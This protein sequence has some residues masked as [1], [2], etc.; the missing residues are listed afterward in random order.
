MRNVTLAMLGV[1]VLVGWSGS[2]AAQTLT[3]SR[4][5]GPQADAQK[6]LLDQYA[7]EHG[8]EIRFDAIDYGQ[9][10][11]KQT[12]NMS[13]KTG[14]YDLIYV[15]EAWFGEYSEAGYL[16]PLTKYVENPELTGENWDM[17]DFS[18]AGMDVYSDAD[19]ALKA[20]PYF[21]Q[22]PL[23]VYNKT[24]LEEAGFEPPQTWDELLAVA[25]YFKEQGT[26]IAL[27]FRQGSAITNVLAVLLAGN[28]TDFFAA[29]GKL[30]L[31]NPAVVETV[32]FMQDLAQ[33]GF[34]GSNGW[35]W[36]EVNKV[37][38]FGQA[39]L[40]ITASGLF[41]ALEDEDQ[42]NVAGQLGYAPIPH[43]KRVA[44]LLQMWGW[45]IPAD[46]KNKEE[47][48]KLAAWLTSKEAL[49]AMSEA[50]PSFIS[51]RQSLG[52]DPALA[53]TAPWLQA[54]NEALA[55]GVTLPLRPAAP[56]LLTSLATGL[57]SVVTDPN[58]DVGGM[59]SGVQ[60]A[61]AGKF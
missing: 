10:K 17:L 46:S 61:E 33:Y 15:P 26:G 57:S 29:D 48:F 28:E 45:A 23:L 42:S 52:S 24:M 39:P 49:T 36:D 20:L 11:Q 25:K 13:T 51:F 47:A 31:T 60:D 40:G 50:D 43:N 30:D 5:A 27:P 53:A 34:N 32:N 58:A 21:A 41:T 54:A 55:S 2:V 4:W 38:Q 19:G 35:H 12:L 22:T 56:E 6:V 8:I 3:V 14:E 44:G 7:A 1:A 37:L 9:L 18:R 16:E 59:L